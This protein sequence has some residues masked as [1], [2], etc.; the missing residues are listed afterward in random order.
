MPSASTGTRVAKLVSAARSLM[1]LR[2]QL[3]ARTG[4]LIGQRAALGSSNVRCSQ[5]PRG[6]RH[7]AL[8]VFR[9]SE[10]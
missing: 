6:N 4:R 5:S 2:S 1:L 7:N 10:P 9:L 3:P 8:Y